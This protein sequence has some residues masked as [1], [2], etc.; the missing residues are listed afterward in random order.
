MTYTQLAVIGVVAVVLV[1]L[2]VA[3]TRL[4]TRRAFWVP[5]AIIVFFQLITNGV[6][7]GFAIVTYNGD[8][9]IGESTPV[10]GPPPFIG[11]GRLAFAPV[12]D[13]LFGFALVLLAL[14]TWVWLGRRGIQRTPLSGPPIWRQDPE[15]ANP[16]TTSGDRVPGA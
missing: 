13:L 11:E 15:R 9:I 3:R 14:V 6:L 10:D 4:V 16:E 1:D 8:V 2:F 5:Y 7:T 12:E